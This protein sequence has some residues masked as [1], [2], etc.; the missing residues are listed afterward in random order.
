MKFL[1]LLYLVMGALSIGNGLWMLF[2]AE[3]WYFEVPAAVPDT[4]DF[5]PHFIRD[6]GLAYF[7]SG[8]GFVWAAFHLDQA[9]IL[10]I[11]QTIF[12]TG[13]AGLHLLDIV[14]GRLPHTHWWVDAPG[15]LVPGLLML[16]LCAPS[17]W[18]RLV[19]RSTH[20]AGS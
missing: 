16:I 18:Y 7:L 19:P 2:A 8:V 12:I 4:G 1:K 13:H 3:H 11:G 20:G 10:H 17:V 9:R 6:I 5:N 14:S 15:V